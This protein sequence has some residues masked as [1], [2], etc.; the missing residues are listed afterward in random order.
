MD[1]DLISSMKVEELKDFLKLRGLKVS[2]RKIELV[3]RVFA[4][5]ENNVPLV[6]TAVEIEQDLHKEYQSKLLINNISIPDPYKLETDWLSEENGRIF[7]PMI[8]YPDI[9]NY[10]VF[11]P[12]ELGSS[13]LCDY[14]EC[15]AYSYYKSGWLQELFYHSID[16]E[17]PFC[18]FKSSCRKSERINDT[19]HKLWIVIE[20]KSSKILRA[21]CTCMAGMGQTCNHIAAALFRI[22]AVVRLGLTN[23]SCTSKPNEWLP[24]RKDVA[25]TKVKN[26]D[27]SREDFGQRGKKKRPL[28]STPKKVF[29]PLTDCNKKLINLNDI[30]EALEEVSPN[31]IIHT[32]V[33]KPE[34]D[35]MREVTNIG[36]PD[37]V[38]VD[39]VILMSENKEQFKMNLYSSMNRDNINKIEKITRGQSDNHLWFSFRKGVV[40]ASKSHD[41]LTKMK[42]LTKGGGGCVDLF[43]VNQS[44]SGLTYINPNIPALKYGR[45]MEDQAAN[46]FFEAMKTAHK[47]IK[48]NNCGLFLDKLVP[49]IGASPDRIMTCDCCLPACVEIKCPYSINYTTPRNENIS[50]PYLKK[51]MKINRNHKYYTQ[52]VVQ[53]GV[54]ELSHTYFLVWTPHGHVIDHFDFEPKIW[55]DIKENIGLY[56][57]KYYLNTIFCS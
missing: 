24:C 18:I 52:C 17:S 16:N 7:W 56:Y 6:K 9:F 4:A 46:S 25:P 47:N 14:K 53:M 20:K 27:F 48:L 2:G 3:A 44:I 35:F 50:L 22:E 37:A 26:I 30:A 5:S 43:T 33:A 38:S 36:K 10:L 51:D 11:H 19:F 15:K 31:S 55:E 40:T 21:H 41:V 54:T 45:N 39:D 57:D 32:A 49:V 34:V 8:L 23:P 12:S 1:Y 42:K 29:N 28:V 13:D